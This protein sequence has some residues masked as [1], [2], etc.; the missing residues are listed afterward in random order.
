MYFVLVRECSYSG[1]TQVLISTMD[2]LFFLSSSC[3]KNINVRWLPCTNA[4]YERWKN[5]EKLNYTLKSFSTLWLIFWR[6]IFIWFHYCVL[7]VYLENIRDILSWFNPFFSG[8][9]NVNR[10]GELCPKM[11]SKF[12]RELVANTRSNYRMRYL[13]CG[14]ENYLLKLNRLLGKVCGR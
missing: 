10:L 3:N 8:S 9:N 13:K 6:K 1:R 12:F 4:L 2:T 11:R 7:L 5:N 14:I